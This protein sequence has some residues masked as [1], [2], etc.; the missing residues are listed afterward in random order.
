[1]LGPAGWAPATLLSPL[2][3]STVSSG[4]K[5]LLPPRLCHAHHLAGTQATLSHPSPSVRSR[6]NN[7]YRRSVN[8]GYKLNSFE[9]GPKSS[10]A[11]GRWLPSILIRGQSYTL[12]E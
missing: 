4:I 5:L 10:Q 12:C 3:P 1:M 6:C 9:C 7:L 8:P 2:P 11:R